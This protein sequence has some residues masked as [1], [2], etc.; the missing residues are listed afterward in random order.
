MNI[1]VIMQDA[2]INGI[3]VIDNQKKLLKK[4][5]ELVRPIIR[6]SI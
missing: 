2:K 5:S 4:N 1:P 6:L 3:R